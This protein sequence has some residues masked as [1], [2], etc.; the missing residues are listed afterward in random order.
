LA[1]KKDPEGSLGK[2]GPVRVPRKVELGGKSK[3]R[4]R[5]EDLEVDNLPGGES[6]WRRGKSHSGRHKLEATNSP[7]KGGTEAGDSKGNT[8][9][10]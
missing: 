4:G 3:A 10:P 1:S 5:G 9:S 7:K 8:H 6:A 2:E